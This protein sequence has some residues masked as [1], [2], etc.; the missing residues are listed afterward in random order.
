M[1]RMTCAS[2]GAENRA[3]VKFCE[4]CGTVLT[5]R[6]ASCG[7]TVP[8]DKKFCG[9]CGAALAGARTPA[10]AAAAHPPPAATAAFASPRS[11]TPPHLAQRILKERA[12]LTGERK[13]VTVLFADVSG[14]TALAER[15]DPEDVHAL[16]DRAFDLMLAEI[17]RYE[18]T[19]NQFLGDGLMALFGAPVALEDHARRAAYAALEMQRALATYGDE[20]RRAR[21]VRFGVRM[22][23]NTGLVVVGAI[24][25]NLRM[26]YTAV[27]D[28]TNTAARMQQLAE[29]G[30]IVI[31]E[32]TQRIIAPYFETRPLGERHVKNRAQP[33]AAYELVGARRGVSRLLARSAVGLSPFVGRDQALATLERAFAAARAG[34]GQAVFLVGDPGMG[35]SRLLLEFRERL[36]ERGRW[37]QGDCSSFGGSTPYLPIIELLKHYVGIEDDDDAPTIIAKVRDAVAALGPDA[38]GIEGPLRYL[39]SVDPGD[40]ALV[41]MDATQRRARLHAAL[42]RALA[43]GSRREP[44]VLVIEDV[45][46]IDSASEEFLKALVDAL[47]GLAVLLILSYRPPTSIRSAS[48][49]SSGGCRSSPSTI[50]TRC[51][52]CA[53]RSAPTRSP[54]TSPRRSRAKRK[55]IRSFS[56]RSGEH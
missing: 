10:P 47:S 29:P 50:R 28:T 49:R 18:G 22:G 23:L 37:I 32:A 40:A 35:K 26:D 2:C 34:R 8:S 39:L 4:S 54:P 55:A 14:F 27:G 38:D 33:V 51:T 13:Q 21:A 30:Q 41:A 42:Q 52:S 5:L 1:P 46:W 53:P 20:L 3:G 12:A 6:C 24:G 9:E 15:L 36:G 56:R 17:H 11:Y 43:A 45:H 25:D 19:V 7:A 16:I 48:A 44:L 31:A